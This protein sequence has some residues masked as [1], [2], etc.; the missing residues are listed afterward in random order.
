MNQLPLAVQ[1]AFNLNTAVGKQLDIIGKYAGVTRYGSGLDGSPIIL[2]DSDFLSFIKIAIV[3]NGYSSSLFAIQTFLNIYFPGAMLV[4]DYQDMRMSYFLNSA[5]GSQQLAQIFVTT[6]FQQL[7]QFGSLAAASPAYSS[8]PAVIQASSGWLE[9]WFGAVLGGNSPA[10]E[11]MNAYCYVMA[12]QI[13]Y[14]MQ[15]GVSEWDSGT[16]YYKGSIVNDGTGK[17][18]FSLVDTNLNNAV[19]SASYWLPVNGPLPTSLQIFTSGTGTYTPSYTFKCVP[20]NATAGATYTNNSITYTVSRT[21]SSS[22]ILVLTGSG[23]PTATGTLT[24]ASGTGDATITFVSASQPLYIEVEMIGAG[25]GGGGSS[26]VSNNGGNGGTGGNSTFGTSLLTANGGTGGYGTGGGALG[27][28]G[29]TATIASTVFGIALQGGSGSGAGG[30][31]SNGVDQG[32]PGSS[33]PFG[34]E[35]AGGGSTQAGLNA[36]TNTGSGGGGGG[37]TGTDYGGGA[38]GGAGGYIKA[39][40]Y[41]LASSYSWAVGAAGTAGSA[42]SAVE[43]PGWLKVLISLGGGAFAWGLVLLLSKSWVESNVLEPLRD[44]RSDQKEIKQNFVQFT[45][46]INSQFFELISKTK[47]SSALSIKLLNS[48]TQDARQAM[49]NSGSA[50]ERVQAMQLTTDKLVKIATAVHEKNKHLETVITQITKD[51]I[52]VKGKISLG[53]IGTNE[54]FGSQQLYEKFRGEARIGSAGPGALVFYGTTLGTIDHVAIFI[55]DKYVLEAGHGTADTTTKEIAA[56]RGA[57]SRIR[58]FH[59]RQDYLEILGSSR[60]RS[61]ASGRRVNIFGQ[62]S[63]KQGSFKRPGG[64]Y[65]PP[66]LHRH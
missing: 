7:A 45:E 41:G 40:I 22:S 26:N 23:A 13:A 61:N 17:A 55:D 65:S 29:G 33:S 64:H 49:D 56:Q 30:I 43:L 27:V 11:D 57:Y 31:A 15:A 53:K 14:L 9:G 35:G 38:G 60:G 42:G 48:V 47:E 18:Y 51:L 39:V 21:V 46:R 62:H 37:A 16:T 3:K 10:I 8:D 34:G 19:T 36:I 32:A 66:E 12:Y 25:G 1:N 54:E 24:K 44:L 52:M 50:I 5:I 58:P 28:T 20:C 63:D 6:G 59:Y 4:F 2:G